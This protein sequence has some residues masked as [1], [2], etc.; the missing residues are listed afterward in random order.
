MM[1]IARY[2]PIHPATPRDSICHTLPSTIPMMVQAVRMHAL[3]IKKMYF[4]LLSAHD[5]FW[6]FSENIGIS[7][8]KSQQNR[9]SKARR[10]GALKR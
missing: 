6:N 7:H 8:T 3:R 1:L 2:V 10:N 4:T 9:I 5:L